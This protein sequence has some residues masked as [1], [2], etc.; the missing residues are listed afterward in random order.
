MK[1]SLET[2]SGGEVQDKDSLGEVGKLLKFL[3][4]A[5]FLYPGMSFCPGNRD[6]PWEPLLETGAESSNLI[7]FFFP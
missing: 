4:T 5:E 3:K 1:F 6:V 7:N 2:S